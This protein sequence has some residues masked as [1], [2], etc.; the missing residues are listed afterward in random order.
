L[1]VSF[2][3]IRTFEILERLRDAIF[4]SISCAKS[5]F[6]RIMGFFALSTSIS[7]ID[8]D[9]NGHSCRRRLAPKK[10]KISFAKTEYPLFL[11]I[12]TFFSKLS[13]NNY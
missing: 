6:V 5:E 8:V 7:L 4:L 12:L 11:Y 2:G 10:G 9:K 13:F 1:D 3:I